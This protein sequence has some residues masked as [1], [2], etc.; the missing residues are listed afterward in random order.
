LAKEKKIFVCKVCGATSSKWLGK[1]TYC[2]E[3]NTFEEKKEKLSSYNDLKK[4]YRISEVE[5]LSESRIKTGF[6]EFDRVTGGGLVEGSVILLAGEPGIGKS[7]LLLQIALNF[8]RN[9]LLYVS[10]EESLTQI[11]MRAERISHK[12]PD[13]LFTTEKD[14]DNILKIVKSY[15]IKIVFIDSI[16]TI[17]SSDNDYL[18]GS[19]SQI[20]ISTQKIIEFAKSNNVTFILIGHITKEGVVAGPKVLE[21]MVDAVFNFEGD[22]NLHYRILRPLKNRFGATS[23]LAVFEMQQNGL[24]EITNPSEFLTS[25][26]KNESGIAIAVIVESVRIFFIEVQALV[27]TS[28]YGSPQ[29]VVTGYDN[30]K[31]SMLLAVLEKRNKLKFGNKDV[32]LN[33]A[34]GIKVSDPAVDL[35]VVAAIIS[36]YYDRPMRD[37]IVFA[38]EIGLAGEIRTVKKLNERISEAEKLGYKIFVT[39]KNKTFDKS[40]FKKIHLTFVNRTY[41][42]FNFMLK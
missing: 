22:R 23:E 37:N 14:V 13:T 25:S 5:K 42:L 7:T 15:N 17:F 31:L 20:R 9:D 36:S 8:Y 24:R 12:Q 30:K 27:T 38:G 4:V 40:L 39:E 32:F 10:G 41:E 3:W 35:A 21:H 26:S 29:R 16:Q 2:G 1:C 18:P 11:K 6:S 34:G 19:I 33:I 28:I